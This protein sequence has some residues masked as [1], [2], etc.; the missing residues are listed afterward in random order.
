MTIDIGM[1]QEM[2]FN[3]SSH[4]VELYRHI[5]VKHYTKTIFDKKIIVLSEYML[6]SGTLVGAKVRECVH[7]TKRDDIVDHLTEALNK[8]EVTLYWLELMFKSELI[9]D[10]EYTVMSRENQQIIQELDAFVKRVR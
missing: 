6:E 4:V 2:A 3:Y 9:N 5:N 7:A 10:N 8:A 1:I